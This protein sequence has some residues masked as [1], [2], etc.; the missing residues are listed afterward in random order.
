MKKRNFWELLET[1]LIEIKPDWLPLACFGVATLSVSLVCSAFVS[2]LIAL[3]LSS[4]V[5][6]LLTILFLQYALI[7][8]LR[9]L[10]EG[11]KVKRIRF[12]HFVGLL[13][14]LSSVLI[15]AVSFAN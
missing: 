7:R 15:I 1:P 13:L 2:P 14:N 3:T 12:A 10:V 4:V 5:F 11:R 6:Y 8:D 9:Y